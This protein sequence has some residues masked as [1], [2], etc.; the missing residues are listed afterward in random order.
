MFAEDDEEMT[1]FPREPSH[2]FGFGS[3][4][5][6]I[7]NEP[8]LLEVEPLDSVNLKQLVENAADSRGSSIH[9]EICVTG[10][11]SVAE[12]MKIRKYRTKGS[13]KPP[14]KRPPNAPKLQTAFDCHLLILNMKGECE[15]LK[16]REKAKDKECKELKG[17]YEAA[18]EYI[19][20]NPIVMVLRQKI[21]SLLAENLAN[22][23]SKVVA[24]EAEKGKLE[25]AKA[26]PREKIKALKCDRAEVVSKEVANLKE[27]LDMAKVKGYRTMYRKEHIKAGNDLA[28]ATFPFLSEVVADPSASVEAFLSKK[29]KSLRRPT[30][31]KNNA[32]S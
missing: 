14:V 7:N 9:K 16:E 19:D 25:A 17:K 28:A 20:K 12:R 10:S 1:F 22:L 26:L 21:V 11:G 24:L 15:V 5:T 8:P 2:G 27:P 18:M 13:A 6:S 23:E 4:S 3:P 31:T 29:P 32:P 30:L